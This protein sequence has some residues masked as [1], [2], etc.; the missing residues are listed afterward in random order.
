MFFSQANGIIPLCSANTPVVTTGV[1]FDSFNMKGYDHACLLFQ[2]STALSASAAILTLECGSADSAD[3]A[4]LTFHYR[5][6]GC[7]SGKSA[8]NDVWGA[9]ASASSLTL[10]DATYRGK[11]LIL[12]F[13]ADDLPAASKTYEWVTAS[14][15]AAGASAG[16]VEAW[17]I[18]SNARYAKN[19]MPT[20]LA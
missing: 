8:S 5:I 7:S 18:L 10:T 11:C 13:D 4:D 17:A 19:I 20:A 9:I 3:S 6:N 16:V 12:E 2:F 14:I 15:A 1:E